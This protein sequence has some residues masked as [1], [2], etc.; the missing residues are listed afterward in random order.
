[1]EVLKEITNNTDTSKVTVFTGRCGIGKSSTIKA[2][3]NYITYDSQ[4]APRASPTGLIV[5]TDSIERL[6]DYYKSDGVRMKWGVDYYSSHNKTCT[7]ISSD[8]KEKTMQEQLIESIYKPVVLISSQKYFL[9]D[10]EQREILF[11]FKQPN[12][13]HNIEDES[14]PLYISVPR[15]LLIF[16]EKPYFTQVKEI[17]VTNLERCS[18]ALFNG[19]NNDDPD[20]DWILSEYYSFRN[21]IIKVLQDKEKTE[22]KKDRFYW[23]DVSS[24]ITKNDDAF[25]N[26]LFKH[27][28]SINNE[29]QYALSDLLSFKQLMN[30]GGIFISQKKSNGQDY[31]TY[32]QI[33]I[34]NRDY[35]YL[36]LDKVKVF[37]FDATAKIDPDYKRDYIDVLEASKYNIELKLNIMHV[38]VNTSRNIFKKNEDYTIQITNAIMDSIKTNNKSLSD[39]ILIATY[40]EI[41]DKF[42]SGKYITGHFGDLKGVNTF[43]NIKIMSHVGL[44]RFSDTHYLMT[45]LSLY[46]DEYNKLKSLDEQE[47][48]RFIHN[49]TRM[50]KGLFINAN[51]NEIMLKT[52]F[53]DFEQNIF[54]TAIRDFRNND[55]VF[56][57]TYWSNQL[58]EEL[59]Y[60]IDERYKIYGAICEY[61]DT[62][63][64]IK[65]IKTINRKAAYDKL[66]TNPQK[67]LEWCN[68]HKGEVINIMEML[69]DENVFM[70]YDEFKQAKR[71]LLVSEIFCEKN[72]I[73]NGIYK[74]A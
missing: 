68:N 56:V 32:F 8:N 34:D 10:N 27:K 37:V 6:S 63:L 52:I 22:N 54:R 26:I 71:N 4:F 24:N 35:F 60:M 14:S 28:N 73:K 57:W 19:I 46:T 69:K 45:Y 30:E 55:R 15:E 36:G 13:N 74:I 40:K 44:N 42:Q 65:K 29:Y 11:S 31:R 17:T 70:S 58:Y 12:P 48:R 43:S 20:K 5:V 50:Q 72:R 47:S 59:N 38:D 67:I 21:R 62:P 49:L 23:K 3:M 25:F 51:I 39:N 16:D 9:M 33:L 66:K 1:M 53:V 18:A 64:S 7:L 61:I 2:F 41:E